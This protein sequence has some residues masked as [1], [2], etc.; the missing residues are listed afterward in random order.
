VS[1]RR[2]SMLITAGTG[3]VKFEGGTTGR[4]VSELSIDGDVWD[5]E[6]FNPYNY[7]WGVRAGQPNDTGPVPVHK[8]WQLPS[9]AEYWL[10][11]EP[12]TEDQVIS[13]VVREYESCAVGDVLT[14]EYYDFEVTSTPQPVTTLFLPGY[15]WWEKRLPP[16]DPQTGDSLPDVI[17]LYLVG[18]ADQPESEW[19]TGDPDGSQYLPEGPGEQL[20]VRTHP[21]SPVATQSFRAVRAH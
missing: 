13:W 1:L 10:H 21:D 18:M 16:Y 12:S 9:G 6:T 8:G 14:F 15:G 11:I 5:S 7:Q 19:L 2:E 17:P 20:M 4:V 3:A